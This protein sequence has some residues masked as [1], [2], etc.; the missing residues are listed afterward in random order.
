MIVSLEQF[1]NCVIGFYCKRASSLVRLSFLVLFKKQRTRTSRSWCAMT[2][3]KGV[4]PF[5]RKPL[6]RNNSNSSSSSSNIHHNHNAYVSISS[7]AGVAGYQQQQ[8][9]T[10][11]TTTTLT[12]ITTL[13]RHLTLTDLIAIGVGG[14]IGSGY[15]RKP[16]AY[17]V[18]D[19][20]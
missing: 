11:T 13:E 8:Q 7:A 20:L 4:R 14:T 5:L 18:V 10:M 1:V 2:P 6:H 3:R 9:E 16:Y 12:T 19:L 15:E 17:L